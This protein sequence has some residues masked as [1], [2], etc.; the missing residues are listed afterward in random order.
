[1]NDKLFAQ[2]T[3]SKLRFTTVRGQVSV[4][5]LWDMPLTSKD[6]FNLNQVGKAVQGQLKD[7]GD[8][9][10]PVT[11]TP[12]AEDKRNTLRLDVIKA[13]IAVKVEETDRAKKA[14]ARAAERERLVELLA[15]KQ[16]EK[17]AGMS[18]AEIKRK[19]KAI[20]TAEDDETAVV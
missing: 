16:D 15:K 7:A 9:L 5:D 8:D 20:D 17:M 10:V 4:E 6:G 3:R 2:A 13:I 18:E 1:M 14:A 11:M 19:L 12:T